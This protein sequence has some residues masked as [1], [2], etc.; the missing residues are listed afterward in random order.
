[1]LLQKPA[2]GF[3]SAFWVIVLLENHILW[4]NTVV[5]LGLWNTLV[6]DFNV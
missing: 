5:L 3:G 6:K 4:A 2:S 1:M